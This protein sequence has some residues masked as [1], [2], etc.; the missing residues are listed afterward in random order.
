LQTK[1]KRKS[2]EKI[3]QT[4]CVH[5]LFTTTTFFKVLSSTFPFPFPLTTTSAAAAYD[6]DDVVVG[7]IVER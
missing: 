6:D 7:I 2:N 3:L 1:V 4:L 5:F